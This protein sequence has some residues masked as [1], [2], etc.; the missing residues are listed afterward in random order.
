LT[1]IKSVVR[2]FYTIQALADYLEQNIHGPGHL[3][4]ENPDIADVA[5][6]NYSPRFFGWHRW[7]DRLWEI[8]QPR[9]DSFRLVDQGGG[10]I[11]GILT[12][13]RPTPNPDQVK[14][15]NAL[16]GTT[17]QGQGS[18][19]I[20]YNVRPETWGR[21]I[22]L[23]INAQVYLNSTDLNPVA[24]LDATPVV[25]NA[26]A[27]GA[28]SGP[29]ELRFPGLDGGGQGAFATVDAGGVINFKNARL[30]VTAHLSPVGGIPGSFAAGA[31]QIDYHESFDLFLVKDHQAP[32][33]STLLNRSA[34][35]LDEIVVNA[36]GAAQSA[37]ENSLFVVLQ[38]SGLPAP[39]FDTPSI[40][41]DPARRVVSG[42]FTDPSLKPGVQVVDEMSNPVTW[43]TATFTDAFP[44][45]PGLSDNASQRFLFR[46]RLTFDVAAMQALL[47]N[48]GDSRTAR[49]VISARDRAGNAVANVLS[50]PIQLFH[51]PH[52]YMIDVI[53][54]N[55]SW[56]SV[57]TRVFSVK[58]TDMHFNHSVSGS[59]SPEQYI[60]D[61]I[62]EFNN[63]TQNFD[64]IPADE[65]Q[66][67]LE[68]SP[69]V[70]GVNVYNFALARVR[71]G[72]QAMV[73]GVQTFFRLFTTAVSDLSFNAINYPTSGGAPP[74]SLLGR[75]AGAEIVSIPCFAAPRIETRDAMGGVSMTTQT[76]GPNVQ[77]FAVSPPGGETIRYFG[78]YL[79]IN[80]DTPRYPQAP[81]GNGPFA[82]G[83]CV[84]IRNIIRGQHQCMVAEVFFA[85]DPTMPNSTPAS[86]DHLA[87]RNLLIVE[88]ANPGIKNITHAAQHSF[89]MVLPGRDL[90]AQIVDVLRRRER[91]LQAVNRG[92]LVPV[93]PFSRPAQASFVPPPVVSTF[94]DTAGVAHYP[95]FDELVFFWNN[96]PTTSTV[97]VYLPG[98]TAEY[99]WIL[100]ELRRAPEQHAL[101]GRAGRKLSADSE[102]QFRETGR[103]AHGHV[104]GWDSRGRKLY[105]RRDAH[106]ARN[107]H[108]CRRLPS[109]DPGEKRRRHLQQRTT[110]SS[111]L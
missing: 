20:A 23:T 15:D 55:P 35:S 29:V 27:Q 3:S 75:T 8:R 12:M 100:R 31:D 54:Q 64:A 10:N 98:L 61:V 5:S 68:L 28:D 87:Q 40:F 77:P 96:L 14:P 101:V 44:E 7:I 53:G 48:A 86:S 107:G 26:V 72:T 17:V 19:W 103:P 102:H 46:H 109:G 43:F 13:I 32:T 11:Q 2:H 93:A 51:H 56:L 65:N 79:D 60:H 30:R 38:D 94:G 81:G 95:G 37:F 21:P 90:K 106:P 99:P 110:T 50:A 92:S 22:N 73:A 59:G 36:N 91:E 25:A 71:M 57:D 67:Q 88:T 70:A 62:D 83:D 80:S 42:I 97:E 41:A 111:S 63:G 16:T 52:P 76:D 74:I 82:I 33:V 9:L 78:A 4:P 84:S 18:V 104:A 1:D 85:S 69:Q 39:G 89:D 45:Q 108:D 34:F 58:Q 105:R 6:N 66:A 47:P 24:G 49:I